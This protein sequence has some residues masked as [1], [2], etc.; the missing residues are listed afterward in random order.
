M[1][2]VSRTKSYFI[3]F[4]TLLITGIAMGQQYKRKIE[5]LI[6]QKDSAW[7]LVNEWIKDA[8][9]EIEILPRDSTKA[10]DALIATQVT[11][12][13]PMGAIIYHSGGIL[14]DKGWIRILGSSHTRLPRSLPEWNKEISGNDIDSA[15]GFLLV[16]DDAIGGYFIINGGALGNDIGKMYYLAPD[17]LEYE[18]MGI[19]YTEFLNFCFNNSLEDFY[20]GYRW[21][22]WQ[23]DVS[24]LGGDETFS[25][26]PFLWTTEAKDITKTVRNTV[27]IK[28][29]YLITMGFRKQLG[30]D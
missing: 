15:S 16:A 7:P 19:S 13:S 10:A 26:A 27:P 4:L 9:N 20:K 25:F 17:N 12:R 23:N 8:K 6:D 14:I 28:E 21:K 11:T 18:K 3:L 29:H 30:F 5:K 22:N 24:G 1:K 2:A